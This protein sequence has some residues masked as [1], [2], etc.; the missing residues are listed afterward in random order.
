MLISLLNRNT[1]IAIG[2]FL[3][4]FALL[5]GILFSPKAYWERMGVWVGGRGVK[6]FNTGFGGQY[7]LVDL[8]T[9]V[10]LLGCRLA[11]AC[12]VFYIADRDV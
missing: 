1:G 9:A 8:N 12:L 5:Q 11:A 4:T 10:F 7:G 3:F 6:E 2:T